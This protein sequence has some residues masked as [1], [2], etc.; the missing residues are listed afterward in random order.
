MRRAHLSDEL[1][2]LELR[3][4]VE[5]GRRLV[6]QEQ[7]GRG[8]QRARERNLLLHPAGE[9]LHRLA[10]P[11]GREA[12]P[13][14]D[15]RD[16]LARLGRG[17]PV[18]ARGVVEVLRGRHL[19]EEARLDG[20][21]VD[22]PPDGLVLA[23]D[24]V[25][26]HTSRRRRPAGAGSRAAGRASTSPSRSGRGSRRTR[27]ARAPAR[28]PSSAATR[29]LPRFLSLRTNSFLSAFASTARASGGTGDNAFTML[30]SFDSA[31]SGRAK[32][33]LRKAGLDNGCPRREPA[34]RLEGTTLPATG[35]V[36]ISVPGGPSPPD[37]TCAAPGGFSMV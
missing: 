34:S 19:L 4:R 18:E 7:H 28:R 31:T 12:D 1:L 11:V 24:V 5:P 10:A 37:P 33:R 25:A 17:H 35:L 16:P 21:P 36:R 23:D 13:P 29:R 20:H 15:L 27:R 9:V 22:E 14:E 3:A 30:L 32:E 26:E 6:E 2:H 8:Q